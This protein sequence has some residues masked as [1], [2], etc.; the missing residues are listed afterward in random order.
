M[1]TASIVTGV[2]RRRHERYELMAQVRVQRGGT[3]YV[4]DLGNLSL[5]G[6]LLSLGSLRKPERGDPGGNPRA[7]RARR[8]AFPGATT[9]AETTVPL[10]V[11]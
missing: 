9:V 1:Q 6:A 2:E 7:G 10:L 5:S 4:L 3:D 11:T 8:Q